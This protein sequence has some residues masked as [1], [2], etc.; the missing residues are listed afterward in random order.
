MDSCQ[1]IAKDLLISWWIRLW[2]LGGMLLVHATAFSLSEKNYY[3]SPSK[4]SHGLLKIKPK[5]EHTIKQSL[6][7][8]TF[9]LFSTSNVQYF[10]VSYHIALLKSEADGSFL[11]HNKKIHCFS[12]N[13]FLEHKICP[14]RW[15]WVKIEQETKPSKV[16]HKAG[17]TFS[18]SAAFLNFGN[19]HTQPFCY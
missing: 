5:Y 1:D 3:N 12:H 4:L 18:S 19:N 9:I 15:D 7:T 16:K 6:A 2:N 13:I 11:Y 8:S 17:N 10:R 14:G